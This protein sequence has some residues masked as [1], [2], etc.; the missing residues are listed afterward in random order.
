MDNVEELKKKKDLEKEK[1]H[2]KFAKEILEFYH[3]MKERCVKD[4]E[5]IVAL[6]STKSS[7]KSDQAAS[8]YLHIVTEC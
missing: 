4:W 1:E 2:R 5:E 6:E 7:P 8:I 3:Q